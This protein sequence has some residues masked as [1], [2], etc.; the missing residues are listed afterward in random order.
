MAPDGAV[1]DL[2]DVSWIPQEL[3]WDPDPRFRAVMEATGCN[4]FERALTLVAEIPG[5]ERETQFDELFYLRFL[6][7][8]SFRAEDL[9]YIARKYLVRSAIRST[10]EEAFES[11]L[12]EF[13]A[14]LSEMGSIG[15]EFPG[16]GDMSD[17]Y[18]NDPGDF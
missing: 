13:E 5:A 9:R 8:T 10:L 17:I 16:L 6:T 3:L 18:A 11:F 1:A 2:L 15:E 7:G 14:A 12:V 4:D